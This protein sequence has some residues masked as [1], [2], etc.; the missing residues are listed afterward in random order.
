MGFVHDRLQLLVA[1]EGHR[2][3]VSYPKAVAKIFLWIITRVG[4][5]YIPNRRFREMGIGKSEDCRRKE[6]VGRRSFVQVQL[7]ET[8]LSFFI[9]RDTTPVFQFVCNTVCRSHCTDD[10]RIIKPSNS[11]NSTG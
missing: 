5:D 8:Q 11:L 1:V 9:R 4:A 7:F 10:S 6:F 3:A 2:N